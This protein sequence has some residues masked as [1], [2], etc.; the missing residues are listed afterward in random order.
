MNIE[1]LLSH[2]PTP[3]RS[4]PMAERGAP[5][6]PFAQAM[7]HAGQRPAM[8]DAPLA[9]GFGPG[10]G[11]PPALAQQMVPTAPW[12]PALTAGSNQ[13]AAGLD[14]PVA[15]PDAELEGIMAR[16]ALIE[17]TH[18]WTPPDA[19]QAAHSATPET[20]LATA[21]AQPGMAAAVPLT[22]TAPATAAEPA[23][24]ARLAATPAVGEAH[25]HGSATP[26]HTTLGGQPQPPA[27]L[28]GQVQAPAAPAADSAGRASLA[29][30]AAAAS[31]GGAASG[32]AEAFTPAAAPP[33]RELPTPLAAQEAGR[34]LAGAEPLV[35]G[36]G[37][38]APGPTSAAPAQASL[39]API[40]SPAWPGQLNQQLV[41]FARMGG[42]QRVEMQLNPAELGP[43]S[44]TL[45]MTEQGAQAQFLSAHA[46]V[47]QVLEQ[48]IPQL[49]EALAE[50]GITLAESSVGEQRQPQGQAFAGH[51][52][53]RPGATVGDAVEDGANGSEQAVTDGAPIGI[54]LDG[55][56]NLYA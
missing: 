56:V 17:G 34:P 1:L 49:R 20:T 44:V 32:T 52:A 33:A 11:L 50:Q 42:E 54:S 47:R 2:L 43:L 7:A 25:P 3:N 14:A 9:A 36:L 55:R 51:Q 39:P 16:L 6:A 29:A 21:M 4:G 35:P 41:Q 40:Q 23:V 31:R 27:S 24:A 48:A 45:K 8:A 38:Q 26:L 18:E 28:A 53:G 5:Q 30:S 12:L 22:P 15:V 37:A 46:Q 19:V 10:E 13:L